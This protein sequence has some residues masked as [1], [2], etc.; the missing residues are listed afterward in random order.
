VDDHVTRA[1]ESLPPIAADPGDADLALAQSYL[2]GNTGPAGSAAAASFLWA[3]VEKGNV[4]AEITLAD[5]Y[6]RGDG[7]TKS[8]EQARVLLRAA[9][10][11]GSSEASQNLSQIIRRD[12]R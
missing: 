1:P 9:S 4:T 5:L 2:S 10:G 7:V 6:A 3:A 8:C 11:K 12:C